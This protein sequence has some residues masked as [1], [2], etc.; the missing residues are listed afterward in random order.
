MHPWGHGH[1]LD[2]SIDTSIPKIYLYLY[3]SVYLFVFVHVHVYVYVNVIW[4]TVYGSL[5]YTSTMIINRPRWFPGVHW[6][7]AISQARMH[8]GLQPSARGDLSHVPRHCSE[9]TSHHQQ[10]RPLWLNWAVWKNLLV[11]DRGSCHLESEIVISHEPGI[12][13]KPAEK[14]KRHLGHWRGRDKR[15]HTSCNAVYTESSKCKRI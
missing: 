13:I 15:Q 14:E 10:S 3:V 8:Q 5:R 1:N 9:K 11:D 7:D 6:G 2:L 12:P 4:Y